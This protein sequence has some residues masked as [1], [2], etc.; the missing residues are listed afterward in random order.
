MAN[1]K[2]KSSAR[3]GA[4]EL[5]NELDFSK[6]KVLGRGL[7]AGRVKAGGRQVR[8]AA[9]VAKAFPTEKSVNDALRMLVQA[10]KS[11]TK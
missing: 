6:L 2:G 8:L 4:D 7:F 9:D 1:G 11:A 10:A 5:P 3:R